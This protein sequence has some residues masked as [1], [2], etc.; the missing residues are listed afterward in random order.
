MEVG[1]QVFFWSFTYTHIRTC[2]LSYTH[3][4]AVTSCPLGRIASLSVQKYSS[5]VVEKCLEKG[6]RLLTAECVYLCV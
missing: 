1:T 3:A 5:N 4:H 6:E 2:S